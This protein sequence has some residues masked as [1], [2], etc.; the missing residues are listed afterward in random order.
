ML[1]HTDE[2]PSAC[3]KCNENFVR[4]PISDVHSRTHNKKNKY[5]G[6]WYVVFEES[7]QFLRQED[8]DSAR[9]RVVQGF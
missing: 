2:K 1:A 7:L 4:T 5:F 8:E 3:K 9:V 6:N